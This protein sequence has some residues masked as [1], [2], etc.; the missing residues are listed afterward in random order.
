MVSK[1]IGELNIVEINR[2]LHK[3]GI[4][5]GGSK[6]DRLLITEEF[7][8]AK[9]RTNPRSLQFEVTDDESSAQILEGKHRRLKVRRMSES[10]ERLERELAEEKLKSTERMKQASCSCRGNSPQPSTSDI[11]GTNH[12]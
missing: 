7:I 11:S 10:V 3:R 4:D 9:E 1:F 6:A 8:S 12:I 5:T 2:E